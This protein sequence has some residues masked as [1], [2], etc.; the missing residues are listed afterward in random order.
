MRATPRKADW[1]NSLETNMFLIPKTPKR[2]S[3]KDWPWFC[4]CAV[5]MLIFSHQV[6][7]T[8]QRMKINDAA[9]GT[10]L[11]PTEAT[12]LYEAAPNV[13]TNVDMVIN[14]MVANVSVTQ[15]FRNDSAT[16]REAIYVFPLP[17]DAAVNRLRMLIGD[18]V[19]EGEIQEREQ[20]KKNLRCRQR[21]W[22]TRVV[23]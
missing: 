16:W 4:A 14:G 10:L 19:I 7:A 1:T 8:P 22:P 15:T 6:A 3:T 17:D 2:T 23:G 20:A 13:H 11:Y 12:G 5:L 18:R 9:A 21:Q